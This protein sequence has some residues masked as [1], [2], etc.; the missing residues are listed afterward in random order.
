[1]RILIIGGGGREHVLAWALNRREKH[2]LHAVPGNAGIEQ[3]ATCHPVDAEKVEE[4]AHLAEALRVEL[5]VVGPEDPLCKGL[6]NRLEEKGIRT[7]GPREEAAALEGSKVFAREFMA[8]HGIPQPRFEVFDDVAAARRYLEKVGSQVVVKADGLAKGKGVVVC[9]TREEA[10]KAIEDALERRIFGRA[11]ER[12]LI[13]ERLEGP[14]VTIKAFSDGKDVAIMAPSQDYKRVNDGNKGP[15][16]G[17]MGCYSPVPAVSPEA[18]KGII[19]GIIEPTV[20]GMAEEG[21]TYKGVLYAGLMLT[22]RGP[23]VL[24]YNC[25][26]GD[27][28]SQV[29][30]PRLQTDLSEILLACVEGRLGEVKERGV[31]WDEEC[32]V[33]VV[34]ASGGYPGE[35]EKGKPIEGLDSSLPGGAIAFHA[36]TARRGGVLVTNGGRVLGVTGLGK[37]FEE[38]RN[39]AYAAMERVHFEGMHYRR[40][41]A[42]FGGG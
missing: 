35:Y 27:P 5:A 26:F 9:S 15:N 2:E 8:R 30:L 11:G 1:M 23:M 4:V 28:E 32:A 6:V 7:F 37:D 38:A 16:T 20:R 40:D 33:C 12:V 17:G 39:R 13:E 34:A 19:G 29:V 3:V 36:G 24:E 21:R 22:K 18:L 41:I 14:E 42:R 25:R 10:G 31:Q